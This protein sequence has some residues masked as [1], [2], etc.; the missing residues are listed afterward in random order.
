MPTYVYEVVKPD[1]SAKPDSR[2]E[3]EQSIKAEALKSHPQTGEPVRRVIQS[4]SILG[5]APSGQTATASRPC[6]PSCG[7]H[8]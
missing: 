5:G 4:I 7:C 6:G 1:G 3:Y 2:F 8:H